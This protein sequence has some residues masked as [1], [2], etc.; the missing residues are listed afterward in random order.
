MGAITWGWVATLFWLSVLLFLTGCATAP[1]YLM[2][3]KRSVDSRRV[4]SYSEGVK[5]PSQRNSTTGNCA[6]YA[7]DYFM[8]LK[9]MGYTAELPKPCTLPDGTGHAVTDMDG[10]RL[11]N[12]YSY[13]MKTSESDCK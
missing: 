4:Y 5:W 12:R 13:V 11:D 1:A 2:D 8:E 6:D 9:R 3:A 7:I 10:W